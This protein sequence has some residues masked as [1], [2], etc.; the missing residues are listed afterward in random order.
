MFVSRCQHDS[1]Q[2]KACSRVMSGR[3]FAV[4][5]TRQTRSC[6]PPEPLNSV[7]KDENVTSAGWH[8]TLHEPIWHASSRSGEASCKLLH[9]FILLHYLR[10]AR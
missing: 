5:N 3:Y 2:F 7:G 4:C 8:A 1:D 9:S 6:I 10:V